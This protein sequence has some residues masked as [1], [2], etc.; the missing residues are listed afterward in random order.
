MSLLGG[1]VA[2]LADDVP[3]QHRRVVGQGL[4]DQPGARRLAPPGRRR[5]R[6]QLG[7]E[8]DAGLTADVSATVSNDNGLDFGGQLKLAQ[9]KLGKVKAKSGEVKRCSVEI[10]AKVGEV[11]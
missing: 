11:R 3:A 2:G 7:A 1:P 9:A 4:P 5:R 8:D 10:R 6:R